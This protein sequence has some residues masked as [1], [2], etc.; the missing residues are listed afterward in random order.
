MRQ[1]WDMDY[2]SPTRFVGDQG[3]KVLRSSSSLKILFCALRVGIYGSELVEQ[4]ICKLR[5]IY[6]ERD[7]S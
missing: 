1:L 4:R 7:I 2:L 6:A 3:W 5:F